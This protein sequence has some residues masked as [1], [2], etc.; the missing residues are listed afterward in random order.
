MKEIHHKPKEPMQE[1]LES[2]RDG[3]TVKSEI[4]ENCVFIPQW[5]MTIKPA[6]DQLD[7]RIAVINLHLF[8]PEWDEPLFECCASCSKDTNTAIGM[9]LGSFLFCFMEGIT[10][11]QQDENPESLE[12]NFAGNSHS[13]KVYK[14][15]SVGMGESTGEMHFWDMLKEHIVKRLG[16]QKMCYVKVFA[17]KAVVQS[18]VQVTGEVRINDIPSPELSKLVERIASEWD[19]EQ[20]SSQKQFFFI[21]QKPETTLPTPYS[22]AEER[23]VFTEKVKTALEMYNACE[24]REQYD[25]LYDALTKKLRDVTLTEELLSFL[26]EIAAE[27]A[28]SQME[29]SEQVKISIDGAEPIECYKSQ[30]ADFFPIQKTLFSLFSAGVFGD[31]TDNIY[32]KLIGSSS[33]YNCVRQIQENG[34]NLEGCRLTSLVFNTSN[35]FKIR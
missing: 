9:A 34:G 2:V 5:N 16:N 20:F 13:W 17:S 7:D 21:K 25:D 33:I 14:S 11:M 30:L 32:G 22:S 23:A 1:I 31:Q 4:R 19:V 8:C 24:S 27:N 35:N 18:D 29:F 12:S 26:P 3:L 15:N 6:I 10:A 28:F